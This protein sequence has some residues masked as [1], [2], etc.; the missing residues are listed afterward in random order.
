MA[1]PFGTTPNAPNLDTGPGV[2]VPTVSTPITASAAWLLGAHFSNLGAAPI[3]V[4]VTDTAGSKL[5][6]LKI[7][8]GAEQPYEW[9]FRP[10]TGVKW[11]ASAAGMVGHVWGYV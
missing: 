9:P 1:W 10:T 3:T 2:A 11:F 6:E 8:K 4:T 5:C 7:P